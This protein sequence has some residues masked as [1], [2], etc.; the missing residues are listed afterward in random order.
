[1]QKRN[2]LAPIHFFDTEKS[3]KRQI[4]QIHREQ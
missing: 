3:V 1:M 2:A 4:D